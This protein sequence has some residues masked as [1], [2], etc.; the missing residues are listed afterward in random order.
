M[1]TPAG[2]GDPGRVWEEM[3]AGDQPVVVSDSAEAAGWAARQEL[4]FQPMEQALASPPAA[5]LIVCATDRWYSQLSAL[6]RAFAGSRALWLPLAAF[7]GSR[8]AVAYGL[9]QL[10]RS[11]FPLLVRRHRSALALVRSARRLAAGDSRGTDLTV[12]FASQV[13]FATILDTSVPAG[14]FTP[15]LG[16]F[17]VEAEFPAARQPPVLVDGVLRPRGMLAAR[18]RRLPSGQPGGG[19]GTQAGDRDHQCQPRG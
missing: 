16:Y 7:D 3:F 9:A 10:A 15:L 19:G 4:P 8:P 6:R 2:R 5:A 11:G 17:E 13:P 14:D 18:A 12:T 1:V